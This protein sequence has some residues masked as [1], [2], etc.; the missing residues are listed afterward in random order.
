M[1]N[2]QEIFDFVKTAP[3]EDLR[4]ILNSVQNELPKREGKVDDFVLHIEDF[5]DDDVLLDGVW[6]ECESLNLK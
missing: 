5:C 1:I 3:V 4:Q 6:A 2:L